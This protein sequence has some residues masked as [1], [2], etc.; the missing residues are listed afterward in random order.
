M[1]EPTKS[2]I[3]AVSET[4]HGMF[5]DA[6]REGAERDYSIQTLAE[7]GMLLVLVERGSVTSLQD[8]I[9]IGARPLP[10]VLLGRILEGRPW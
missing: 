2:H 7:L 9:D 8:A 5:K 3:L 4:F 10:A 1:K 6:C